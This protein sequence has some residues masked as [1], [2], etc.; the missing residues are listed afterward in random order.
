MTTSLHFL[1]CRI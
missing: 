1:L